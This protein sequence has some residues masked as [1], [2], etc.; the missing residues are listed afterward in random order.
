MNEITCCLHNNFNCY[1]GNVLQ[2]N[3]DST[4]KKTYLTKW[5]IMQTIFKKVMLFAYE[6]TDISYSVA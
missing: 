1:N 6:M 4:K 5:F 2:S 3:N